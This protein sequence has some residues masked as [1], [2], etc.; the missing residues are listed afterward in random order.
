M[1]STASR[2]STLAKLLGFYTV[3][4]PTRTF[5]LKGI[6]G[7][8]V[9]TNS[10]TSMSKTLFDSEWIANSA[11]LH[12]LLLGVYGERKQIHCGLVDT[13]GSYTFAKTL[14]YKAKGLSGKDGKDITVIPPHEYK[15]RFVSALDGYFMA[16]PDKW[17][18]PPDEK[19]LIQDPALLPSVL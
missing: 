9:K 11:L 2:G 3:E 1:E 17:T 13:I 18:K 6:Q 19:K 5:D 10:S 7:R 15:E 16:C 8:K 14:E 12:W 4:K